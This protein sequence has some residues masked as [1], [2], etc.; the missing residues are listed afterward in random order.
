MC[1]R[2]RFWETVDGDH[3]SIAASAFDQLS[4]LKTIALIYMANKPDYYEVNDDLLKF[5]G[6]SSGKLNGDQSL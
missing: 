2:D 4:G 5:S 3:I 1:I 6:A